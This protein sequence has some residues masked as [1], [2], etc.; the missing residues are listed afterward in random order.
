MARRKWPSLDYLVLRHNHYVALAHAH[1]HYE[2]EQLEERRRARDG[3][4]V[5]SQ[6]QLLAGLERSRLRG[7]IMGQ[8]HEWSSWITFVD[9]EGLPTRE[10]DVS[11]FVGEPPGNLERFD[12]KSSEP[13]YFAWLDAG[14]PHED[15]SSFSTLLDN[16]G[17]TV[18]LWDKDTLRLDHFVGWEEFV[19]SYQS[20][21]VSGIAG[22]LV[23][24]PIGM[25]PY[26][27]V[28]TTASVPLP[29]QPNGGVYAPVTP[30][31]AIALVLPKAD[32]KAE[33]AVQYPNVKI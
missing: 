5:Q 7:R 18:G 20:W 10:F 29:P 13:T 28:T 12:P 30:Q 15:G 31:D 4:R 21:S 33:D 9:A 11:I 32:L 14:E 17:L 2:R 19:S 26:G 27:M 8:L 23:I 3:V 16:R 22:D 25:T 24:A 6:E 1:A